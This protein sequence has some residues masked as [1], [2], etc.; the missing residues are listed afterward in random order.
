MPIACEG[1]Y[2]PREWH[3][4][5]WLVIAAVLICCFLIRIHAVNVDV[6]SCLDQHHATRFQELATF[7]PGPMACP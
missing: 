1:L 4:S 5:N 6:L 2:F 3:N 7:V